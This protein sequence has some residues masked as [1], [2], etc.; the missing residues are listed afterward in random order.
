[1]ATRARAKTRNARNSSGTAAALIYI[2][3][4]AA[5]LGIYARHHPWLPYLALAYALFTVITLVFYA[6]DKRAAVHGR[7]RIAEQNLHLL[8]VIGG[9]PGA[10]LARPLFRH[11]T[12][13][14]PFS[15]IF[16]CTVLLN[17][18]MVGAL[19]W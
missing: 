10:M 9:W 14:Q 4:F 7:S 15:G 6:W 16:W 3:V 11:K 1:M 12:R 5:V 13:K 2:T 18:A 8:A 19:L 17:M